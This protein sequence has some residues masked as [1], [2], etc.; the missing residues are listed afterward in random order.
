MKNSELKVVNLC[1]IKDTNS[2]D[3]VVYLKV[4]D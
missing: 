4:I 2:S 1:V 3:P